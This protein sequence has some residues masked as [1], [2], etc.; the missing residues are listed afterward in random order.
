DDAGDQRH[1]QGAG[2]LPAE[3]GDGAHGQQRGEAGVD[4]AGQGLVDR[5]VDQFHVLAPAVVGQGLPDAVV[6]D[7]GVVDRVAE[8]REDG[9]HEGGVHRQPEDGEEPDDHQNVVGQGCH[10]GHRK[11]PLETNGDVDEHAG[12]GH[13]QGP[14][15]VGP[16]HVADYR[17]DVIQADQ[18]ELPHLLLQGLLDG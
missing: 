15:G 18:G 14:Q 9:G 1:G 5:V 7:D 16:Q 17:G 13:Y 2:G 10:G 12:Y 6:D 4:G 8:N 3:E 11:A